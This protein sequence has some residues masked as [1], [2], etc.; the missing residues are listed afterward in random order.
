[1]IAFKV[2]VVDKAV[3]SEPAQGPSKANAEILSPLD[4]LG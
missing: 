4:N 3:K 2:A 1:M